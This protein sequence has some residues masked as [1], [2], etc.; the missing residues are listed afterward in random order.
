MLDFFQVKLQAGK[1]S[2]ALLIPKKGS[3]V[4]IQQMSHS[5]AYVSL[6]GELDEIVFM[7]GENGGVVKVSELVEKLKNEAKVIS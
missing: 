1:S 3:F 6:F 2:G 7:D 4:I 5:A